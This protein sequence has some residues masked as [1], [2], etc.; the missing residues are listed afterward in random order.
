MCAREE[1]AARYEDDLL[2]NGVRRDDLCRVLHPLHRV[3]DMVKKRQ[4]PN[5]EADPQEHAGDGC[6]PHSQAR[7]M[8]MRRVQQ[9][10]TLGLVEETHLDSVL[11]LGV[12]ICMQTWVMWRAN[13][14]SPQCSSSR[15]PST[16]LMPHVWLM[17]ACMRQ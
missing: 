3:N 7:Q 6:A 17:R 12:C 16:W 4:R 5:Q 1:G 13:P 15:Y 14:V 10:C 9:M 11:S 2:L 8:P